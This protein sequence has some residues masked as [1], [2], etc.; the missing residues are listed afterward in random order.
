MQ[1]ESRNGAPAI[2]GTQWS[3]NQQCAHSVKGTRLDEHRDDRFGQSTDP[4]YPHSGTSVPGVQDQQDDDHG[5]EE[6][7]E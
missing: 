5:G 7:V 4:I 3:K 6:D 1:E 2:I